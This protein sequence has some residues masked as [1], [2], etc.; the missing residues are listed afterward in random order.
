MNKYKFG[1]RI[2]EKTSSCRVNIAWVIL[3]GAAMSLPLGAQE[4][5]QG[6][7]A[8][9]LLDLNKVLTGDIV[10]VCT[11]S[12]GHKAEG[13]LLQDCSSLVAAS[14]EAAENPDVVN[15]VEQVANEEIASQGTLGVENSQLQ[16]RNVAS[17]IAQVQTGASPRLTLADFGLA[18]LAPSVFDLTLGAI[19]NDEIGAGFSRTAFFVNGAFYRGDQDANR[20]EHGF[21]W[22]AYAVT[23]GVDHRFSDNFFAGVALGYTDTQGDFDAD[24]GD[25]DSEN[26]TF[27]VFGS[28]YTEGGFFIDGTVGYGSTDYD[29]KRAVRY[30]VDVS[31]DFDIFEA[32][33]AV[34]NQVA[35]SSTDG[36][37]VN[38]S[39]AAGFDI[40]SGASTFTPRLRVDYLDIEVDGYDEEM[41]D[42][43]SGLCR[44]QGNDGDGAGWALAIGDQEIESLRGA[45]GVSWQKAIS[46]GW[47]VLL[48]NASVDFVHEFEDDARDV[49]FCFVE[50]TLCPGSARM[51][52]LTED[53]LF[54]IRTASPDKN[55]FLLSV[56][57]VAQW[58]GGK[59]A[60]I[61]I[62]H[63]AGNDDVE[64][65]GIT[66]G[67]RFEFR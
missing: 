42:P 62:E 36:D 45:L 44:G 67:L 2:S 23:A 51:A 12:L 40:A 8:R 11:G 39:V 6:V 32:D 4:I 20:F 25:V 43:L 34:V 35:R 24:G 59:T 29:T 41:C 50:D 5:D 58:A 53:Q 61:N 9:A 26:L 63:M 33:S 3:A 56:G 38:V 10:T 52:T 1:R 55:F 16:A 66:G 19:G 46:R 57:F 65:T 15:A 47:G 27:S 64:Y 60:F 17:R 28:F 14:L 30:E 48:P 18:S 13:R 54:K 21:D 31:E 22:D 37:E 49:F 7:N